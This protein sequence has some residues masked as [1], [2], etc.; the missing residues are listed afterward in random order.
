MKSTSVQLL[1]APV[2]DLGPR[3]TPR[4]ALA[5]TWN[6]SFLPLLA[7]HARL[8]GAVFILS[9]MPAQFT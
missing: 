7:G 8:A 6:P 2:P 3:E 4:M 5:G 1:V 9:G